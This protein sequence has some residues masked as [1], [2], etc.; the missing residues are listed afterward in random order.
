MF[1]TSFS[2]ITLLNLKTVFLKR[3]IIF[4]FPVEGNIEKSH[5]NSMAALA[6]S[7]PALEKGIIG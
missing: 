4:T 6:Y 1:E 3:L 2:P 7:M 5:V